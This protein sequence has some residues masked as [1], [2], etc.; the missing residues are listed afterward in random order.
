MAC[1]GPRARAGDD[2]AEEF[3]VG[4]LD[5]RRHIVI[6]EPGNADEAPF[7]KE[8]CR[9]R[10]DREIK[11]FDAQRGQPEHDADGGREEAGRDHP[12]EDVDV[13][14]DRGQLVA[15][16]SPHPHERA[17]AKGEQTRVAGEQIK[18]DRRQRENEEWRHHCVDQ[19]VVAHEGNDDKGYEEDDENAD[20][21]LQNREY[22]LVR[23]V[24]GLELAG[25]AVKHCSSHPF[26]NAFAKQALRAEQ[27]EH[28]RKYKGE[29]G[30]G[31]AA[32]QRPPVEFPK[33]LTDTDIRPPTIAP[34]IEVRPPR[35]R[36]G[37]ALSAI[38][39]RAKETSERAPHMMPVTNRPRPA[40]NHTTTHSRSSEIPTDSAAS[41]LSATARSARPILVFEKNTA[42]PATMTD[43]MTAAAMSSFCT[44]MI[45]PSAL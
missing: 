44:L 25:L 9:E 8:L 39:S 24:T 21:I 26:D 15:G 11:T 13:G 1:L 7:E 12:D 14:K 20:A 34:G 6:V 37:S 3:G 36:T 27:K 22:R 2:N 16:I 41:W 23:G 5:C 28:Q 19:E 32:D 43:A 40:A 31:A 45:P 10:R 42:N 18:A 35:M 33:L 17:G 30:I 4:D 38:T 29:P